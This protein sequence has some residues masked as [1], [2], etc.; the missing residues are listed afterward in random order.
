MGVRVTD[1]QTVALYDSVTGIS[2]GE[3]FEDR[4]EAEDFAQWA[5]DKTGMDL[6]M[7]G[8]VALAALR[9]EWNSMQTYVGDA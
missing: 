7:I 3:V 8:V 4:Q 1:A 5:A 2:F 9:V 6:R